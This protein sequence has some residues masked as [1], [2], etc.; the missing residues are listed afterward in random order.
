VAVFRDVSRV[1]DMIAKQRPQL[2]IR[3]WLVGN[4]RGF[5]IG[6]PPVEDEHVVVVCRCSLRR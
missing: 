5:V 3:T 1:E 2:L 6:E 4:E